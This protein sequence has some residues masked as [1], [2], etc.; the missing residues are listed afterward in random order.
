MAM[1]LSTAFV[2]LFD[3]EVKQAYQGMSLLRNTVRVRSGIQGSSHKFPKIGKGVA[4][5][6]L[7]QSDVTP[8]NVTY[9]M[10]TATLA[11]WNASEYSDIFMQ[12]HV[13]FDERRELVQVVANA[14]ARRQ[15]QVIIDALTASSTTL[16]VSN[17]IGGTDSDWNMTKLRQTKRLMDAANVP[18]GER[19]LLIHARG[20][21]ALLGETA[22]T[23]ADYNAV[24]ALVQGEINTFMG[25]QFIVMGD[26]DEGGV[27]KDGSN[28]R[29][30]FAW[31]KQAV[32]LAESLS[33]RT[34]IDW[35]AEKR[36][37]LVSCDFSAGAVA[38]DDEG[39]VKVT[40]RE[41]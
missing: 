28:D 22:V 15:D 14:I 6:R 13:N 1:N 36:S 11:D 2:T 3:A 33:P 20:L 31:H 32:G 35:I 21:E 5:L 9:A 19:F 25:F 8:L 40:T 41:A 27:P 37:F 38:I 30:N 17:D 23:S 26:R 39:I 10:A 12:S 34:T 16:T 7:P 18:P 4:A 29:T 24:K